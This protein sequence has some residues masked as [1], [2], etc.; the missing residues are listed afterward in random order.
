MTRKYQAAPPA[1]I[2]RKTKIMTILRIP[3]VLFKITKKEF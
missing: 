3:E 2:I 1:I